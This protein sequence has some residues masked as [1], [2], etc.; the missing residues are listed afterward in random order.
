MKFQQTPNCLKASRRGARE[1]LIRK[2]LDKGAWELKVGEVKLALK[3]FLRLMGLQPRNG[4]S[5]SG[6]FAGERGLEEK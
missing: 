2:T 1:G 4:G 5:A 3:T 6:V